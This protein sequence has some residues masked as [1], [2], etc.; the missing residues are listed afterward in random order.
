MQANVGSSRIATRRKGARVP[1]AYDIFR[2]TSVT[3]G[4]S[5]AAKRAAKRATKQPAAAS[6]AVQQPP[7]NAARHHQRED[8]NCNMSSDEEECV[9]SGADDSEDDDAEAAADLTDFIN[10][11]CPGITLA[12]QVGALLLQPGGAAEDGLMSS[13]N[14]LGEVAG[15]TMQD[16]FQIDTLQAD[17]LQADSLQAD[18]TAGN[19]GNAAAGGGAF[20]YKEGATRCRPARLAQLARRR[21]GKPAT[22]RVS[23]CNPA[24]TI[25][26]KLSGWPRANSVG[27]V[28]LGSAWPTS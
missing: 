16:A 10:G 5:K 9:R 18:R 26:A 11:M 28:H 4:I 6:P 20:P 13:A 15:H 8:S 21:A 27:V 23:G 2:T 25:K 7:D 3:S 1:G 17:S 24:S 14:A 19:A 22:R 12:P